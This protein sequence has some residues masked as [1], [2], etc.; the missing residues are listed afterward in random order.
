VDGVR[1]DPLFAKRFKQVGS[2]PDAVL[3]QVLADIKEFCA[4]DPVKQREEQR[5]SP[6]MY[7]PEDGRAK[8][9]KKKKSVQKRRP[10]KQAKPRIAARKEETRLDSNQ[11]GRSLKK[12]R[13]DERQPDLLDTGRMSESKHSRH[14]AGAS[15]DGNRGTTTGEWEC[16]RCHLNNPLS[17]KSCGACGFRVASWLCCHSV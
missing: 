3:E 4:F 8:K 17:E 9:K 5:K 16:P 12:K 7:E 2:G 15:A 6:E 1:C 13:V 10:T 14:S 11:P